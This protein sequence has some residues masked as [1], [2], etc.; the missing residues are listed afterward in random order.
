MTATTIIHVEHS[1]KRHAG[2]IPATS[3]RKIVSLDPGMRRGDELVGCRTIVMP[4]TFRH[5][6][7]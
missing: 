3:K 6:P 5:P 4:D 2:F 1:T 7:V